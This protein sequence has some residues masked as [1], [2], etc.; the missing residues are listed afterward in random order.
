[1]TKCLPWPTLGWS[2]ARNHLEDF[3]SIDCQRIQFKL[4]VTWVDEQKRNGAIYKC[5]SRPEEPPG[6]GVQTTLRSAINCNNCCL[7]SSD[8]STPLE[9]ERYEFLLIVLK[10]NRQSD[11]LSPGRPSWASSPQCPTSPRSSGPSMRLLVCSQRLW[12]SG[13]PEGVIQ[14]WFRG[15]CW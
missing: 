11:C 14:E 8:P 10:P 13:N 12:P 5:P 1:M 9:R 15:N 2:C 6:S 3:W 4:T 7:P